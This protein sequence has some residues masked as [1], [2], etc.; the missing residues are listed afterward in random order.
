[1]ALDIKYNY[2]HTFFLSVGVITLIFG[3]Y[4]FYMNNFDY[5]SIHW[6]KV[7]IHHILI[8]ISMVCL[9]KGFDL[10]SDKER[11]R[12]EFE[13]IRKKRMEQELEINK[14]KLDESK[15][16]K[17]RDLELENIKKT[18]KKDRENK[19]NKIER[20]RK[21][22]LEKEQEINKAKN[23]LHDLKKE[24]ISKLPI[25][26]GGQIF[27]AFTNYYSVPTNSLLLPEANNCPDLV[28]MGSDKLKKCLVCK[29]LVSLDAD[30]CP[31]CRTKF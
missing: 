9:W 4:P 22:I 30:I 15:L 2:P 1:M 11:E 23:V 14:Q 19:E 6:T 20:L 26:S 24:E 3:F 28:Y 25:L 8:A 29:N 27:P 12:K 31:F 16:I 7:V 5:L 17:E 21:E 13:N 18:N 10:W